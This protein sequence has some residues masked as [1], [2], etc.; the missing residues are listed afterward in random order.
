MKRAV[1]L[2]KKHPTLSVPQVMKLAVFPANLLDERAA[3]MCI[4][5]RIKKWQII[6]KRDVY[7]TPPPTTVDVS[8]QQGTLSSVT[9]SAESVTA[10]PQKVKHVRMTA[11]AAQTVRPAKKVA[12][13]THK[14]AIKHATTVYAREKEKTDGKSAQYV[15]DLIKKEFKV[16]L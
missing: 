8:G 2:Y 13:D 10:P 1:K 4:Y 16:R 14:I 9:V 6:P 5:R 15:V 11:S 12:A 7:K 3:R